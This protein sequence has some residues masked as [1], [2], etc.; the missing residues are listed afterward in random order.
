MGLL[1]SGHEKEAHTKK[2][3]GEVDFEG[4]NISVVNWNVVGL[5]TI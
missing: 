5:E 2:K 3:E 4:A 1:L